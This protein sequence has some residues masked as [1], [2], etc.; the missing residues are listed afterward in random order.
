M[1]HLKW[2]NKIYSPFFWRRNTSC[3]GS[4]YQVWAHQLQSWLLSV[5]VPVLTF[6]L[7]DSSLII[8]VLCSELR[9]GSKVLLF[10][11]SLSV[12]QLVDTQAELIRSRLYSTKA[13]IFNHVVYFAWR[14]MIIKKIN[15]FNNLFC[16]HNESGLTLMFFFCGIKLGAI[17]G[18]TTSWKIV[19]VLKLHQLRTSKL[20]DH[21]SG[22]QVL[23][24]L[25]LVLATLVFPDCIFCLNQI[26]GIFKR[27]LLELE[28]QSLLFF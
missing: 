11:I 17:I 28:D 2:L 20:V 5:L 26:S 8:K 3:S 21:L 10:F 13:M 9:F 24:R 14:N 22:N 18:V 12:S 6:D 25:D 16:T 1:K 19:W 15:N 27:S 4:R 7:S 23:T